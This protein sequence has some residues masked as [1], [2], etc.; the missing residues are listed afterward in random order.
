MNRQGD[1]TSKRAANDTPARVYNDRVRTHLQDLDAAERAWMQQG[2]KPR[3]HKERADLTISTPITKDTHP[4]LDRRPTFDEK[5]TADPQTSVRKV[6]RE[7]GKAYHIHKTERQWSPRFFRRSGYHGELS[8]T[9]T[10]S[11]PGEF[12]SFTT[13]KI[14]ERQNGTSQVTVYATEGDDPSKINQDMAHEWT[15]RDAK[16]GVVEAMF[17]D[18]D[19]KKVK[20]SR[21]PEGTEKVREVRRGR[22]ISDKE[23]PENRKF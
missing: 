15:V 5:D 6:V 18:E 4:H 2:G 1:G 17:Y 11:L 21:S 7:E 12:M 8:Q 13:A 14:Q 19:N 10:R 23:L 20:Y 16:G 3:V 9:T 22:I